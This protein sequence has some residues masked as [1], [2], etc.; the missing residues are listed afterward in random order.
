MKPAPMPSYL[1]QQIR[2]RMEAKQLT[3]S[4]LEKKAG[5]T[6]N[7]VWQILRG[8]SK[9]PRAEVL[10]AVAKA[11]ECT[12]DDLI[13]PSQHDT[14][15]LATQSHNL[16]KKLYIEAATKENHRWNEKLYLDVTKL[17]SKNLA[18]KQLDLKPEQIVAL[19]W[20]GYRYSTAKA[21]DEGD[22]DFVNWLFNRH[23]K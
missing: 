5:T 3:A 1:Q 21:S 8:T 22:K 17:V 4:R 20:E 16:D 2:T 13:T 9:N 6:R 11:L 7:A 23:F 12:V 10:K 18:E 19:I 15:T 14:I